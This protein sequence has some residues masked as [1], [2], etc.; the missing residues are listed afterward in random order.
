MERKN[1][2]S[3]YPEGKKRDK[4]FAFAEE[5]RQFISN[6][7]TERECTTFFEE[8]AKKA[9]FKTTTPG[10]QL[11]KLLSDMATVLLMYT[12]KSARHISR[13]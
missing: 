5:Y 1:A 3:K 7:K 11:R 10:F 13:M 2:W 12:R 6:A 4:V 8:E 9:G